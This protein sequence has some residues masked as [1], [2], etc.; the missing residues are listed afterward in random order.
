MTG[1]RAAIGKR[2][3]SGFS[4]LDRSDPLLAGERSGSGRAA[5][6][7]SEQRRPGRMAGRR[8]SARETWRR[9]A[10]A[11]RFVL[12]GGTRKFTGVWECGWPCVCRPPV[13]FRARGGKG[14]SPFLSLR[15]RSRAKAGAPSKPA[16]PPPPGA[17]GA[18][19]KSV[20]TPR[21]A[22][23]MGVGVAVRNERHPTPSTRPALGGLG[24]RGSKRWS[25]T[26][27]P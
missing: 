20:V 21:S 22:S 27:H 14:V 8:V 1:V 19:G 16:R 2:S 7:R 13:A 12:E 17:K 25:V 15:G 26:A 24:A 4:G 11:S 18:R 3:A 10:A 6:V 9:R 23:T 5:V